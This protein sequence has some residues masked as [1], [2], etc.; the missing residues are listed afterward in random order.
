[1][2]EPLLCKSGDPDCEGPLASPNRP[3]CDECAARYHEL[4]RAGQI[5]DFVHAE[6]LAGDVEVPLGILEKAPN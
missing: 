2:T 5:S 6:G 3:C 4:V 1:M